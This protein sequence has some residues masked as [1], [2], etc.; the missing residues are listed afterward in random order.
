[1]KLP[2]SSD[3]DQCDQLEKSV[4]WSGKGPVQ[5]VGMDKKRKEAM[6]DP[7][8]RACLPF[9]K[10]HQNLLPQSFVPTHLWNFHCSHKN[11]GEKFYSMVSDSPEVQIWFYQLEAVV[12]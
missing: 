5:D 6:D 9:M 3:V 2:N 12:T 7:A 10:Q 8:S 11:T 1:M 4:K